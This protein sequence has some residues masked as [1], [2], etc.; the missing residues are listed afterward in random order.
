MAVQIKSIG[1]VKKNDASCIKMFIAQIILAI[2]RNVMLF[3]LLHKLYNIKQT[4]ER[5]KAQ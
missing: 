2:I 4:K 5:I 1:I 3:L